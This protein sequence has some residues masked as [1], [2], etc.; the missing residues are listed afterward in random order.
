M[1]TLITILNQTLPFYKYNSLHDTFSNPNGDVENGAW[2]PYTLE[3]KDY[4]T[5]AAGTKE[6]RF[7]LRNRAC[8]FWAEILPTLKKELSSEYS[9]KNA[10]W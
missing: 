5:I 9:E 10:E 8:K 1:H 2:E 4:M 6:M 7:G 3:N